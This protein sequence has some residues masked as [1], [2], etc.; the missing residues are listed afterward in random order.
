VTIAAT[1]ASDPATFAL[2]ASEPAQVRCRLDGGE[3]AACD[4]SATYGSLAAGPHVFEAQPTDA[5]GN[6]GAVARWS[7][8]V[9]APTQQPASPTPAPTPTAT[10]IAAP[11]PQPCRVGL[12]VPRQRLA[13]VRRHGFVVVLRASRA[14]RVRVTGTLA[15]R[16]VARRTVTATPHPRRVRLA[17]S[18]GTRLQRRAAI[19]VTAGAGARSVTR[20]LPLRR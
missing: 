11:A 8:T 3:W 1:T 2:T 12:Q 5:A 9:P 13:A 7:W 10:P 15:G 18:P 20:R 19:V 4:G 17:L 6:A 14:C 16:V